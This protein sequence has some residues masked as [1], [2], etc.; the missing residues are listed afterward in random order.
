MKDKIYEL[1]YP[2]LTHLEITLE[3]GIKHAF[4]ILA[5]F[6]IFLLL[7]FPSIP[8]GLVT[9][10][11][12]VL[13]LALASPADSPTPISP[14]DYYLRVGV[15]HDVGDDIEYYEFYKVTSKFYHENDIFNMII[16][17]VY[18]MDGAKVVSIHRIDM[19]DTF[20][21]KDNGEID[22]SRSSVYK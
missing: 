5:I 20:Y 14:P 4:G 1:A 9:I 18:D 12:V 17:H 16:Q 11:F 19:K 7:A 8:L 22:Y 13:E 6:G 3:W 21:I 10:G 2:F 15:N